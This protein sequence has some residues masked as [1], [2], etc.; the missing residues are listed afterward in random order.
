MKLNIRNKEKMK[1]KIK[2][3]F[4]CHIVNIDR[5]L[6]N[7]KTFSYW[8]N[9]YGKTKLQSKSFILSEK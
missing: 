2:I 6:N 1:F 8:Y 7:V 5:G 3:Q 4:V 9:L